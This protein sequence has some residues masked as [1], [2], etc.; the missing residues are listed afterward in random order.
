LESGNREG[1]LPGM[2]SIRVRALPQQSSA[3]VPAAMRR[4]REAAAEILGAPVSKVRALWQTIEPGMYLEADATP[5]VQP[6]ESHPPTV[7]LVAFTGRS[8]ETIATALERLADILVE[9]L[10][11]GA[12]NA[13]VSYVQAPSGWLYV[14]GAIK[15]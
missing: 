14:D 5:D 13:W 12:G 2:P 9:E 8:D 4:M 11:L 15:H 10:D 3:D 1:N 7:E 6:R